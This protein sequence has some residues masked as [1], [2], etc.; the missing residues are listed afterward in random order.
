[1]KLMLAQLTSIEGIA[2]DV[3]QARTPT[4]SNGGFGVTWGSSWDTS[5][6]CLFRISNAPVALRVSS[7]IFIEDGETVRVVGRRN[8][9]GVF[10]AVAYYNRSSGASGRAERTWSQWRHAIFNVVAGGLF[11]L[12]VVFFVV[13]SRSLNK[14]PDPDDV[15][16]VNIGIG[17]VAGM[18]LALA[19]YGL[20]MFVRYRSEIRTIERLLNHA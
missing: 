13:F 8:S 18:G 10:D 3:R 17:L 1:M 2:S 11:V 5:Y 9:N 4:I 6:E 16:F 7:P 19:L 20:R 12:C 14:R 15:L